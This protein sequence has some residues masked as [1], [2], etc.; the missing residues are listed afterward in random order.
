MSSSPI[1]NRVRPVS[2]VDIKSICVY[3]HFVPELSVVTFESNDG[4]IWTFDV[5]D[6]FDLIHEI[7]SEHVKY[8][9][10]FEHATVFYFVEMSGVNKEYINSH[11]NL[12]HDSTILVYTGAFSD[13]ISLM[14]I[15]TPV[16]QYYYRHL[17][18]FINA[19]AYLKTVQSI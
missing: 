18:L 8:K 12:I 17:Q 11:K 1:V 9:F 15:D 4:Q 10:Y 3:I 14:V 5:D 13:A 16:Y 19:C 7:F 6:P 2:C